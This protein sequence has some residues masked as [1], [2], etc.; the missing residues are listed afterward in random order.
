MN[1]AALDA[2]L[3]ACSREPIHL[4]GSIQPHGALLVL[5]I[6]G[7]TLLQ[8]S[9]NVP[10]ITG[11]DAGPA[12]LDALVDPLQ[13]WLAA[14]D[15]PLHR[16]VSIDG[17]RLQLTA[18][19]GPQGALVE[20]E[21]VTEADARTLDALYPRVQRFMDAVEP[22]GDI[23]A[24]SQ[25]AARELRVLTGFPRVLVY[26]FD[27]DWHGTV[28]AEDGDGSLPSYLDLRFPASDIPAQARELYRRNRVRIIPD[29]NYEPV[30]VRPALSPVDGRPLDLSAVS[31]RSVSP[32]HLEYMRNMG[33]PSS[34]SVSIVIDGRL[35]G[36]MSCHGT[37]PRRLSP[38][39]LSACDFLGQILALQIGARERGADARRRLK[40][41]DA[42]A[43]LLARMARASTLQ[44]GLAENPE[45]WLS[46]VDA[47]GAAVVIDDNVL[48]AGRTPDSDVLRSLVSW[49]H[50][51]A[52]GEGVWSTDTLPSRFA[53]AAGCGDS[54]C[55][56]LAASISALHPNYVLWFRPELVHTVRWGGEPDKA[57]DAAG[58]LR[59]RRS[60]AQW[61]QLVRGRSARWHAS[62]LAAAESLRNGIIHFVLRRAE[63]R[64]ALSEQLHATNR[65]LEAFSYSIS[66]DLR[67]PF[68]HIVGFAQLLREQD[69]NLSAQSVRYIDT[70]IEAALSAGQLVDDLLNFSQLG[71]STL[72]I[73]PV[74]MNKLM[75]EVRQSVRIDEGQRRVEW[76]VGELP[77]AM[78]DGALL[79][80]TLANLIDNALK[81]T[82]HR[83]QAVIEVDGESRAH[84]TVYTV[85]DNGVGFDM[86]YADK[87]F[88]VFQRLHRVE[89]FEGSGIGLAL[90]RRIV[91]RHGGWIA[92][93]GAVDRGATFRFGLP[94]RQPESA[95]PQDLST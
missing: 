50:E 81:Y 77:P 80:Q 17:R 34:M 18:H 68:R 70:I 62:D 84:E 13:D 63:E 47:G 9:D 55:G 82:R 78:G 66:H 88:G 64:A 54:A 11:R 56:V 27:E 72:D 71:R 3:E 1:D 12:L 76:R 90:S 19:A 93:E 86:T 30:P 14:P 95:N 52:R 15:A 8:A 61:T 38:P 75:A 32:V 53:P 58:R 92:A 65:E 57:A 42:E 40:A 37:Q 28:I 49:L 21:P 39:V 43:E 7:R 85:R 25:A 26:R 79:R 89:D 67:A 2:A 5:S 48:T 24:V 74:D 69:E 60:F 23:V 20:L 51:Q 35:W 59:P 4:P 87:L 33:T 46:L 36:L 22:E 31:L 94:R 45:A 41:K 29:A 83:E 44:A 16:Q 10:A 73:R 6:D 91:D